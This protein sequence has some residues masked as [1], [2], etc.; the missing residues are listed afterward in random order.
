[1][2]SKALAIILSCLAFQVF[3]QT[4]VDLTGLVSTDFID[5]PTLGQA[6]AVLDNGNPFGGFGWEVVMGNIG[7][8]GDY[9]ARFEQNDSSDWL[10]DWNAMPLY[11]S[12]HIL[13]SRG[14][15]D[16]FAFASVGCSG[17]VG[18]SPG[19][20]GNLAISLFPIV[21]AGASIR[22]NNL[23]LGAKLGYSLSDSAI[24]ATTIPAYPLGRF[25]LSA[26]AG[27]SIGSK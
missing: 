3:A 6:A 23:R 4:R 17:Q 21:G 2:K 20:A 22:L 11:A 19:T 26:Y 5:K 13:G 1:M 15:I 10:V 9:S 24:P 18:I 16:P 7:L 12:F 27:F 25:Q 14:F 8:G